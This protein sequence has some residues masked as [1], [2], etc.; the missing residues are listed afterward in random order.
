MARQI[1]L[2]EAGKDIEVR[3]HDPKVDA[4]RVYRPRL[5]TRSA[6]REVVAAQRAF[7]EIEKDLPDDPDEFTEEHDERALRGLCDVLNATLVTDAEDATKPGDLLFNGWLEDEVTEEQIVG[8]L[9]LIGKSQQ[10][11][12]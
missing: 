9:E 3:L 5:M 6:K 11:P 7:A 10:D 12:T 2:P 1:G 4:V 8:L